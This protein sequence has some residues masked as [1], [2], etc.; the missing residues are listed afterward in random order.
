MF[1]AELL[2]PFNQ[3]PYTGLEGRVKHIFGPMVRIYQCKDKRRVRLLAQD[4]Q[5]ATV[6]GLIINP[7]NL[8]RTYTIEGVYTLEGHRRQGF[9]KQLLAVARFTLGA[10]KHSD[11]LTPD[12]KAWRD[13]VESLK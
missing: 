12:G 1:D 13:S 2:K 8:K 3:C 7:H 4:S 5:G 9:A 10:V 6:A 11:N